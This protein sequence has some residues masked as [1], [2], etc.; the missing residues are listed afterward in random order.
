MGNFQIYLAIIALA[1][2][3]C[4]YTNHR[5]LLRWELDLRCSLHCICMVGKIATGNTHTFRGIV[6]RYAGRYRGTP[7][8][9]TMQRCRRHTTS[10][11][12]PRAA[13]VNV[14]QAAMNEHGSLNEH[15]RLTANNPRRVSHCPA[16]LTSGS[17]P[18]ECGNCAG[19]TVSFRN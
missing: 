14:Q 4:N 1:W 6:L 19:V 16:E 13:P 10:S 15:S 2:Q 12:S 5:D 17:A 11:A 18:V 3:H 8:H 9:A 7:R